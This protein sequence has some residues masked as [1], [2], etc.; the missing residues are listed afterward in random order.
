MR[1]CVLSNTD[2]ETL[3]KEVTA[4]FTEVPNKDVVVPDLGNPVPFKPED[5][6]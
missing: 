2:I 6:G 3:E 5:L 4:L 1:L